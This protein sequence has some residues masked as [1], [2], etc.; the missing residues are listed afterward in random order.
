[1]AVRIVTDSTTDLTAEEIAEHNIR[2]ITLSLIFDGQAHKETELDLDAFYE[3][4]PDLS[5]LPTSAQPTPEAIQ[6]AFLEVLDG[7]DDV[8]A[9]LLS[10]GIS[11]TFE[12]AHMVANQIRQQRPEAR[13]AIVDSKAASRAEAFAVLEAAHL[14]ADGADL[15]TCAA[16]AEAVVDRTRFLFAPHSLE[17]LRSGGR[18]GRA[19]ALVGSA[20]KLVPILEPDKEHGMVHAMAKVRTFSRALVAIK[21]RML[22]DIE[23]R[24]G[25]RQICVHYAADKASALDFRK[26]FVDPLVNNAPVR[27]S[28]VSPVVGTHTG[29]AFGLVYVTERPVLGDTGK[30]RLSALR[31]RASDLGEKAKEKLGEYVHR[32]HGDTRD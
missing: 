1:M 4:L 21:D 15:D 11:G 26:R 32:D 18:I 6:S 16:A 7:G 25:L 8:L 17:Y 19:S 9:V 20:L 3:R 23:E 2:I 24:G 12:T 10:S 28:V 27:V 13:I 14:A 30:G 22:A 29:P 31:E 5:Q